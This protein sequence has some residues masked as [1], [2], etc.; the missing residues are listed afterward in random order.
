MQSTRNPISA[1]RSEEIKVPYD[2][3]KVRAWITKVGVV[4]FIE[5]CKNAEKLAAYATGECFAFGVEEIA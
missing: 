1:N 5:V 4:D 2:A 3:S